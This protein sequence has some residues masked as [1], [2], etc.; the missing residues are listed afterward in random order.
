[1]E[2]MATQRLYSQ[3]RCYNDE[4]KT[5]LMLTLP[6]DCYRSTL[7][8]LLEVWNLSHAKCQDDVSI[9]IQATR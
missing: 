2:V 8:V 3:T 5:T 4:L 6:T 7:I 9:L 1:M